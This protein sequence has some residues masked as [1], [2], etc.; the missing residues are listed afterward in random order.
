MTLCIQC[1]EEAGAGPLA[2]CAAT[3]AQNAAP[4]F[5]FQG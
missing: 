2:V 5:L 4:V 1:Q 3:P